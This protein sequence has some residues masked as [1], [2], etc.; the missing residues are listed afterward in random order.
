MFFVA[1]C[2]GN[3]PI[4]LSIQVRREL[5][6]VDVLGDDYALFIQQIIL[7]TF[8]KVFER[9]DIC[10]DGMDTAADFGDYLLSIGEIN[11]ELYEEKQKEALALLE[12]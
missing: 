4:T 2:L 8:V 10:E 1:F 7:K 6:G 3:S 5:F 12:V 11:E 9:A